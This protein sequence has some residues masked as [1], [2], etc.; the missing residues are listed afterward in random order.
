MSVAKAIEDGRVVNQE[1]IDVY[2]FMGA[3]RKRWL[4]IGAMGVVFAVVMG[5][6]GHIMEPI[7]RTKAVLDPVTSDSNPLTASMVSSS[8]NSLGGSLSTLVGGS[9]EVD[10]DIDEAMTV[11]Q[12]RAFTQKFLQQNNVLPLLFPKLWDEKAGRWK[13]GV[14][15]PTLARGFGKFDKIR[16]VDLDTDEEFVIVTLDWPDRIKATEWTNEMIHMLNEDLRE[17]AVAAADASLSY[18]RD[19]WTKTEDAATREAVSRLIES[20][21]RQKMLASVTPEF[22]LRFIDKAM[23]PDA[24]VRPQKRVMIGLGFVFGALL[25]VAVSLLLYRR[26]LAAAHRL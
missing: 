14:Q 6:I 20:Q 17:R 26:E 2:D 4:L 13:D 11:L 7:Y 8:L 24:P 5:A 10:R 19:E 21:L 9:S 23:V 16:K 22:E 15:V 25:G 3:L 18:L 1:L 12:S